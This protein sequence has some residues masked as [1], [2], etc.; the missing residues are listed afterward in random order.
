MPS[1]RVRGERWRSVM[2]SR[3]ASGAT[4]RVSAPVSMSAIRYARPPGRVTP[5]IGAKPPRSSASRNG[6]GSL[7][8][9]LYEADGLGA[10]GEL[11]L[12][13][14]DE[15]NR[16]ALPAGRTLELGDAS[17][18]RVDVGE[19]LGGRQS[20]DSRISLRQQVVDLA[21]ELR[22]CLE[23]ELVLAPQRF[24]SHCQPVSGPNIWARS[25]AISVTAD[26]V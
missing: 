21:P 24:V 15:R 23:G 4:L 20:G 12:H 14:D 9:T 2:I 19:K 25:V 18:Q 6:E 16:L 3:A 11:A 13:D 17:Q 26:H 1:S 8:A 5:S 10:S 22:P 7:V